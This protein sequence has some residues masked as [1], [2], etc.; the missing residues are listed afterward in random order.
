MLKRLNTIKDA[1]SLSKR[2]QSVLNGGSS[3]FDLD[4]CA[5]SCNCPGI[6]TGR[7][8]IVEATGYI[9]VCTSNGGWLYL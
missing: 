3:E 6:L 2:A 5:I 8:C 4:F 1:V 9:A 7:Q